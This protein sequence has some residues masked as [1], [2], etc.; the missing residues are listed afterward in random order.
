MS[1][2]MS[3]VLKV[4][5]PINNGFDNNSVRNNPIVPGDT[6]IKNLADP[7][8]IVRTDGK[9]EAEDQRFAFGSDSNYG[10]FVK[11]LTE[12]PG[13]AELFAK[14]LITDAK[15]VITSGLGADFAEN[16]A[17]FMEMMKMDP[18][19]LLSFLTSQSSSSGKFG[20][21]FF[22]ALHDVLNH[23]GSVELRTGILDFLKHYSDMA[24]SDHLLRNILIE[25]KEIMPYMFKADA[26]QLAEIQ[27]HLILKDGQEAQEKGSERTG[28]KL[29]DLM[30]SEILE[31]SRILKEE[32]IPFFSKYITKTKDL[33]KIRDLMTLVTLNVARY[34]NGNKESVIESFEKLLQFGD[35][36]QRLGTIK[37]DNIELILNRLLEEQKSGE[38]NPWTEKLVSVLQS[39]LKGDGGYESKMVFQNI[40]NAMLLNESVYMPLVH[41]MMPLNLNGNIMFSE[42][43]VDPDASN[44]SSDRE[45]ERGIR[46]LIK[47]D[48][49][50]LGFFDVVIHY[51]G[52]KVDMMV[53][54][55]PKLSGMDKK[56]RNGLSQIVADNGLSPQALVVEP[57][58]RPVSLMDVFPKISEGR[59][60]VNVRI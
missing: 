27:S 54:Y 7:S 57:G 23:T 38:K 55:P 58:L 15:T 11:N 31:N 13:M 59:N 19:Q 40:M 48:I 45:D 43:W 12:M 9:T 5:Q 21:V 8:K 46:M 56:I 33:G 20:G 44:G 16:L 3:N 28:G 52:G 26:E 53:T 2:L 22:Q 32:V 1:D 41:I 42:I 24:S 51:Q 10:T 14:L 36:R 49:K 29:F 35:F 4:N 25:I 18:G 6:N 17:G 39:G 50:D 47:F 37:D 30:G 34:V 60:S